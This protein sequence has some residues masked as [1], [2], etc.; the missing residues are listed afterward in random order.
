MNFASQHGV[1]R[2]NLADI[3]AMYRATGKQKIVANM[4]G[5]SLQHINASL[6]SAMTQGL[7]GPEELP[8]RGRR[9]DTVTL[10][11]LSEAIS[12]AGPLY[13]SVA[14]ALRIKPNAIAV[15][16]K[17][18][19]GGQ[20]LAARMVDD[21]AEV[22]E[23]RRESRRDKQRAQTRART[24]ERYLEIAKNLGHNPNSYE[25]QQICAGGRVTYQAILRDFG[26]IR[27]FFAVCGIKVGG[28]PV[29]GSASANG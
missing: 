27:K 29:G 16:L 14:R 24:I 20:E 4:C 2:R 7:I 10:A 3:V 5:V 23:A 6:H 22:A 18:L 25:L 19:P 26:G 17:S 28:T 9:R 8:L 1:N 12:I 11:E 21:T 13:S 15:I